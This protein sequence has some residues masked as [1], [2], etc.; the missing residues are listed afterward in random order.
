MAPM[1]VCNCK[2]TMVGTCILAKAQRFWLLLVF[3]R[4]SFELCGNVRDWPKLREVDWLATTR[5]EVRLKL[6]KNSRR[7]IGVTADA[8]DTS[9]GMFELVPE[10]LCVS[11]RIAFGL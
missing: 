4:C 2:E 7:W 9:D 1:L 10:D 3:V 6:I 5:V 11:T 8:T